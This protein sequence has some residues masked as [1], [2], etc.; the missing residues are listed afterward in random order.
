MKSLIRIAFTVLALGYGALAF[1]QAFVMEIRGTATLQT[2]AAAPVPL[3]AGEKLPPGA[4]L[5]TG[6][7][8]SVVLGFPDKQIC[9][10]GEMSA[11]RIVD[12]RYEPGQPDKGLVS[13]NLINGSLRIAVGDIGAANPGAIRVQI[14][15]ATMGLLPSGD[16]RADASVVVLGG[17]V[18]VVVQEGRAIILMPAGQPQEIAAGQGMY[19]GADGAVRRGNASQMA[20]VV[21]QSAEGKEILK[22]LASL[23]DATQTIKQTV[24]VLA[25]LIGDE[26]TADILSAPTTTTTTAGAA[27]LGGGGGGNVASPN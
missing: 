25:A 27:G 12:Y 5:Q 20:D 2:G 17:P 1:A 3:V 14:G 11:F 26:A 13:L 8:S 7:G 10:I 24:I 18:S 16:A 9:V 23:Q 6:P 4:V 19:L 15:V 22:L 21:G